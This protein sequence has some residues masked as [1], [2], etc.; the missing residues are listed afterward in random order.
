MG[1]RIPL[2]QLPGSP[3][4]RLKQAEVGG[5]FFPKNRSCPH[6]A[7][8]SYETRARLVALIVDQG[9]AIGRAIAPAPVSAAKSARAVLAT[10]RGSAASRIQMR[11]GYSVTSMYPT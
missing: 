9:W 1:S 6:F 11:I 5:F 7:H 4:L 10:S 3:R 8:I 2:G